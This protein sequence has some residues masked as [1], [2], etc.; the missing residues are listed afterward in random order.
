MIPQSTLWVQLKIS[1]IV[2]Y[3][4][5]NLKNVQTVQFSLWSLGSVKLAQKRINKLKSQIIILKLIEVDICNRYMSI[6]IDMKTS[7]HRMTCHQMHLIKQIHSN[8]EI[9]YYTKKKLKIVIRTIKVNDLS[10]YT[11]F[12][13]YYS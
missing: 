3:K 7:G 6:Y 2:Y 8:F 12:N 1:N 10:S 9:I 4:L 13:E 5:Y 11:V